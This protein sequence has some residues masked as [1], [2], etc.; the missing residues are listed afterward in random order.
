MK[1]VALITSCLFSMQNATAVTPDKLTPIN[2]A[3]H[4]HSM[5]FTRGEMEDGI[6]VG[7]LTAFAVGVTMFKFKFGDP[8]LTPILGSTT[9]LPVPG[10]VTVDQITSSQSS[11]EEKKAKFANLVQF[12]DANMDNLA[13]DMSRGEGEV[14]STLTAVW[15]IQEEPLFL[16]LVQESFTEVFTS[17]N[18][19]SEEIL[20]NL[21]LLVS[22]HKQLSEYAFL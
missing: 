19:T 1:K 6:Q 21:N 18:V 2:E 9:T 4:Y 11:E 12:V 14:L 22:N 8:V 5:A 10:M 15:G 13:R 3:K 20:T 16:A 17:E 7:Y